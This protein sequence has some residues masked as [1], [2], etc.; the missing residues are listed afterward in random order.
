MKAAA[1]PQS[2]STHRSWPG[3]AYVV[4]G[5]VLATEFGHRVWLAARGPSFWSVFEALV[6]AALVV[7]WYAS[8]R[9]AQ[10]VQDRVIRLEMQL[11][12]ERLLG[13][14]RRAEIERVAVQDLVALRFA[15]DA[16]LPKLFDDVL[17]G[18]FGKPDDVKRE[19]RE[20]RADWL[21]V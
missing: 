16:E 15:S 13:S 4:A 19:V 7:V 11:R 1:R 20:W 5:L 10:V 12:L 18:R 14:N 3:T 21:R 17:A 2:F 8:R 6:P 9:R